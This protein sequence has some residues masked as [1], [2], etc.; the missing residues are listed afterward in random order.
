LGIAD[1]L[2]KLEQLRQSGALTDDEFARA[3]EAV[4]RGEGSP[5]EPV[6]QHVAE[7]LAEVRYQN[8]LARIDR[9]WEIERE[10]YMVAGKYGRRYIPTKGMSLFMAVAGAVGGLI[11]TIFATS[12]TG[13]APD[14]G[15]FAL[16]RLLFP[17]FGVLFICAAV[18]LGIYRYSKAVA[19]EQAQDAYRARRAAV[20]CEDMR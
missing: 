7:Q 5:G 19:Y 10:K 14:E 6:N 9:E 20:R 15:P 18:G 1:E 8:E 17:A 4:L 11:W 16:A 12:I 3:K 2:A 13:S